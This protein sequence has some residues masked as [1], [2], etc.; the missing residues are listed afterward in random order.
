MGKDYIFHDSQDTFYRE[1]FGAVSIG[2]KVNLFLE[3]EEQGD[4]FIEV[5]KFD[6]FRYSI[7]MLIEKFEEGYI[8]YR[9]IIDTKESLGV[10]NYYF[11]HVKNGFTQYYGNNDEGLGGKGK[12]YYDFPKPYQITVFKESKVPN[13]YKEGIIYQ[14]FVDRFCNGNK[15]NEILNK[16]KNI[17]I[18]GSWYDKPMYIRDNNGSIERWD[19]YGGNLKGV[20]DNLDY[21]KS[22]GA[23]IIYMNPIFDA[24]SCHKYDT[25]DYENIDRMYGTNEEFKE[26]CEEAEEKGIKI[27]LD[28]VFSHTGSDSR[29]FN[30]HGNYSELGAYESKYSKYYNWYRFYDYPNR[31]E[32]WWGF[33]NQPNVE[34]L[35]PSYVDYIIKNKN[36]I[37]SMW[38]NLGASGWRLDVA[39]ELPDEFIKMIKDK[40]KETKKDSILIGEVWEDASNKVSYSKKRRYLLGDELDSVTNYPFKNTLVD[41]INGNISS[42]DFRKNI[43]SLKENYPRENFY[44][45][46]NL[47]GNHDTERILTILG[48][49]LKKLE[50]S[51][52]MQMTLPGV[53]LIYYGDEAG[54]LG[55]KDPENRKA[56]PWGRENKE[57]MKIYK[58]FGNLR[59]EEKVLK[60]GEIYIYKDLPDS[61]VAF[62]R[63]IDNE[64]IIIIV[65]R[66]QYNQRISLRCED[67][68]LK[69]KFS[70]ESFVC[71][72]GEVILDIKGESYKILTN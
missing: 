61:I 4:V 70:K 56:Y 72:N 44:S 65:N 43:M 67:K 42:N 34:E 7:P 50:L 68:I 30:K 19:F 33:D 27:I 17:F 5:T 20:R 28:G 49:S 60:Y 48:E 57:I 3:C 51:V 1:P 32:C 39:D 8:L 71:E 54:L 46:M 69:D 24:V 12:I 26:L 10:I 31:Y 37:I 58:K 2:I 52:C 36:S 47:L 9:G 38:L 41:F 63:Y 53:P 13:W 15:N 59:K 21:I 25:G 62:S 35:E 64:K 55:N 22:L 40:M 16:K 29:Y 66:S 14:I 45:A 6:G 11:R 18:Y 23:S